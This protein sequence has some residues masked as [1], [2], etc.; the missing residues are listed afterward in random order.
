MKTLFTYDT[1]RSEGVANA[2]RRARTMLDLT[3]MPQRELGV[4]TNGYI[5]STR[6]GSAAPDGQV[7]VG[8]PYSS[9]RVRDAF[10]GLDITLDTFM[11]A[12]RNPASVFYTQD[13]SDFDDPN[14]NC[15]IGN[16]FTAYGTV[17][18]AFTNYVLGLPIHRSTREWGTS[19]E[20]Y[21]I[22]E[23]CANAVELGDS[24]VTVR[25][26]GTTGGHVRVITGVGRDVT[27]HV[28]L[29]EISEGTEPFPMC[30]WFTSYEFN[31]FLTSHKGNYEI[32][33]CRDLDTVP[34]TPTQEEQGIPY[35]DELMLNYG[36]F[37]NYYEG[38]DVEIN[39][40]CRADAVILESENGTVRADAAEFVQ[41][42]ILGKNCTLCTV[43]NL[44]PGHYRAYCI[45][46]D[47]KTPAVHFNVVRLPR[48]TLADEEGN[49]FSR[50]PL[51]VCTPDGQPLRADSPCLFD[52]SGE[53]RKNSIAIALSDGK[54][55]IPA[56]AAVRR[57][58]GRIVVRT[59]AVLTDADG[60]SIPSFFADE[61]VTLYTYSVREGARV[62]VSYEDG[63]C[64]D[65][66]FLSWKEEAA[67]TYNQRLLTP[68][69]KAEHSFVT[70]AIRHYNDF[71]HLMLICT[72]EYGRVSSAVFPFVVGK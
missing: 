51:K 67:I 68:E 52:E 61:E 18:S 12:V 27:G 66:S 1:P 33:R 6:S 56:R 35:T 42:E 7:C 22:E 30:R 2:M 21:K 44:K 29:I 60:V 36:D 34:Y 37:S 19:P 13:L 4:R 50:V 53:L 47:G 40:N 62:R 46:K 26:D 15:L 11:T 14:Y 43:R 28:Q 10:V 55:L 38:E 64:C 31:C 8:V 57:K 25:P 41:K 39:I 69:E 5:Y 24:I 17:C 65:A 9:C 70:E 54:R 20:L 3:W 71:A 16:V 45:T 32:Y 63:A 49:G 59:A 72:N 23:Q 48:L 58:N